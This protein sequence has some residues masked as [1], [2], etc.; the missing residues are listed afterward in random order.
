[1]PVLAMY[2]LEPPSD[3]YEFE[4]IIL[5]YAYRI[6]GGIPT[7]LGRRG[8]AQHGIDIVANRFDGIT[9]CFQCKDYTKKSVTIDD[10]SEWIIMAETSPIYFHYFVIVTAARRDARLSEYIQQV[11]YERIQQGRWPVCMVFWE[12]VEHFLKQNTY[13]MN[14]YY[15]H[16]KVGLESN[17][18]IINELRDNNEQQIQHVITSVEKKGGR[19]CKENELLDAFWNE[20][21]DCRIQE[22]LQVD[23]FVGFEFELVV[24]SDRFEIVMA[25]VMNCAVSLAKS[26]IY[27]KIEAFLKS[28]NAFVGYMAMICQVSMDG[29]RT[30]AFE[31]PMDRQVNYKEVNELRYAAK[32]NLDIIVR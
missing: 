3:E 22:L 4:N 26:E 10:I 32:N 29:K 28:L 11:S 30:K 16:I 5:D 14:L 18:R 6:V 25:D 17:C 9:V 23:P 7:I 8:Q 13:L 12:D 2:S 15:P 31:N 24:L 20:L 21:V 1:M 27:V 19:I